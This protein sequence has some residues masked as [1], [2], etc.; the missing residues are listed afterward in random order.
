MFSAKSALQAPYDK[1]VIVVSGVRR[2]NGNLNS[3]THPNLH[4]L[5]AL[6]NPLEI[7][8]YDNEIYNLGGAI[9]QSKLSD[10]SVGNILQNLEQRVGLGGRGQLDAE[11]HH[12]VL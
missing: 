6:A 8:R 12:S 9:K 10:D 7:A 1:R 4:S 2:I 11:G 3:R 5:V